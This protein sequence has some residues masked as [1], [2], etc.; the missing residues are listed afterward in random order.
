[1]MQSQFA[2]AQFSLRRT[3][4]F[5]SL[6]LLVLL[7]ACNM[8]PNQAT[9]SPQAT[10]FPV[11]GV[12]APAGILKLGL[13]PNSSF[14]IADHA[15][16]FC[17]MD[18]NV[19]NQAT[20]RRDASSPGQPSFYL[21]DT[22]TGAGFVFIPD[23]S[24]KSRGVWRHSFN[25]GTQTLSVGTLIRLGLDTRGKTL[26][27]TATALIGTDLYVGF[28]RTDAVQRVANATAL[29]PSQP[30]PVEE[31]TSTSDGGATVGLASV[32]DDLYIADA[33]A[34]SVVRDITSAGCSE[35][36]FC[37]TE[38][39]SSTVESPTALTAVGSHL[40]IGDLTSILHYDT[41]DDSQEVWATLFSFPTAVAALT[42]GNS[43]SGSPAFKVYVGDDASAGELI[44]TGYVIDVV[45]GGTGR[46]TNQPDPLSHGVT[47]AEGVTAPGGL[48]K[49]GDRWWVS[50]HINGFCRLD[51]VPGNQLAIVLSTCKTN[52]ISPGGASFDPL[53]NFV[54]VPDNSA[55]GDSVYRYPY[56][57]STR[58]L[59]TPVRINLRDSKSRPSATALRTETR[60]DG[61]MVTKLFVSYVRRS[62]ISLVTSTFPV[63]RTTPSTVA[64]TPTWASVGGRASE[65]ITLAKNAA[66]QPTLYAAVDTRV[67]QADAACTLPTRCTFSDTTIGSSSPSAV[68]SDGNY[69]LFIAEGLLGNTVLRYN[70]LT[71]TT[72]VLATTG[73]DDNGDLK[74]RFK[75]VSA[76][77]VEVNSAGVVT[78]VY[79]ADDPSAGEGPEGKVWKISNP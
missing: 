26:R 33:S 22:G 42:N 51:S 30:G 23:N 46:G 59:G 69:T 25:P 6:L 45:R 65:S 21:S 14:W 50:D 20:C 11:N 37:L 7:A 76:F 1:M 73:Y 13:D 44:G 48:L 17:R 10:T 31:V 55:Q 71:N 62:K 75:F 58:T 43:G 35:I 27:P 24:S 41:Q 77:A 40:F 2:L 32:G 9:L 5:G 8:Q 18:T 52:Q 78:D 56:N 29:P 16:G 3:I 61:S 34:I 70:V 60:P 67:Q 15:L 39:T 74:R 4:K 64:L 47:F 19:I 54:Y 68:G 57:P 79:A 12:T 28:I 36:I 49:V 38:E 66:G 63:G 72:D 53:Y